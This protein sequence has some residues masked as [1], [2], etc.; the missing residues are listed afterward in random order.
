M[1]NVENTIL[2]GC[3][4]VPYFNFLNINLNFNTNVF[5]SDG[6]YYIPIWIRIANTRTDLYLSEKLQPHT[7]SFSIGS[8]IGSKIICY[9]KI[10]LRMECGMGLSFFLYSTKG[11]MLP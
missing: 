10:F 8:G 1:P 9:K 2:I 6:D 5:L 11:Y 7:L 3:R 4:F